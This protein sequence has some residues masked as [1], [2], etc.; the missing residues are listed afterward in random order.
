MVFFAYI[1][2]I[3]V[4]FILSSFVF[5]YIYHKAKEKEEETAD[6]IEIISTNLYNIEE[7]YPNCTVQ[8]LKNSVTGEQSIGWWVNED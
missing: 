7:V 5:G 8:V 4:G 1:L 6:D 3:I 2:G